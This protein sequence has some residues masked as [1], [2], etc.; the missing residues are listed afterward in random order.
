MQNQKVVYTYNWKSVG[1]AAEEFICPILLLKENTV[2]KPLP[3]F[4]LEYIFSHIYSHSHIYIYFSSD[5]HG[6]IFVHQ[7]LT[8][9]IFFGWRTSLTSLDVLDI[10]SLLYI[11]VFS[12]GRLCFLYTLC[13]FLYNFAL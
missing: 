8:R 13:T 3:G 6:R 12:H 7:I 9:K 4:I 11:Y 1:C 5:A 10:C 2:K